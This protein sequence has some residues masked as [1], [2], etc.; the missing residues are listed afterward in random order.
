[1]G[2]LKGS[3][4]SCV[5]SR[6]LSFIRTGNFSISV[7]GCVHVRVYMYACTCA[8]TCVVWYM[9]VHVEVTIYSAHILRCV[10]NLIPF[11]ATSTTLCIVLIPISGLL[12]N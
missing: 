12:T 4:N 11:C 10:C 7:C 8:C 9:C 5:T 3:S 1:M 2:S 6:S